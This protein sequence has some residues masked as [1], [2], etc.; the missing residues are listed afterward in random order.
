MLVILKLI[1][2]KE[3]CFLPLASSHLW[4]SLYSRL[5][6]L[7][8]NLYYSSSP[9]IRTLH[10]RYPE[11]NSLS[12]DACDPQTHPRASHAGK[13]CSAVPVLSCSTSHLPAT[14]KIWNSVF[15][16]WFF[17]TSHPGVGFPLKILIKPL[18]PQSHQLHH[19]KYWQVLHVCYRLS[20]SYH[21][22]C[23]S[24]WGNLTW[25][26]CCLRSKRYMICIIFTY[27]WYLF[28]ISSHE[29]DGPHKKWQSI[30]WGGQTW[31]AAKIQ[32]HQ[33]TCKKRV[34]IE[35]TSLTKS[36]FWI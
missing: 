16:L 17:E 2:I 20:A 5:T 18:L 26:W 22:R 19:L 14:N 33:R 28:E 30:R 25:I 24:I 29:Q 9:R 10:I 21:S 8:G 4:I 32:I 11:P 31:W 3:T 13:L 15:L 35:Q 27:E 23:L 1:H 34:I 7:A 36:F 6:A 12:T